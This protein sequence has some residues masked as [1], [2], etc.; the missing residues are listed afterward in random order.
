MYWVR[1]RREIYRCLPTD[2]R[3][4]REIQGTFGCKNLAPCYSSQRWCVDE[5][6]ARD[7][8]LDVAE[9]EGATG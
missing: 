1:Q 6:V 5:E 9:S 2:F 7:D 3:P 4:E 8:D